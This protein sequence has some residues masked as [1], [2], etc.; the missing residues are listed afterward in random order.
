MGQRQVQNRR[1]DSHEITGVSIVVF[2]VR[3]FNRESGTPVDFELK[4]TGGT[5]MGCCVC[6]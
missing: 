4:V 6:W 2:R 5:Q 3:Y 1:Y